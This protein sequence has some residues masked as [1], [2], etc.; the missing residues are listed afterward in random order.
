MIA[1]MTTTYVIFVVFLH[2]QNFWRIKF[3]LKKRVNYDKIHR[4]L[5]IF[6]VKSLK[7]YTDQK[8]FTRPL[9]VAPVTNMRYA[10]NQN[11]SQPTL[12]NPT[13]LKIKAQINDLQIFFSA[14]FCPQVSTMPS[15]RK[16]RL[17]LF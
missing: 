15:Q 12:I 3:T 1:T 16:T 2:E 4:K 13:K 5:P 7:I 8:K 14:T 10:P 11:A 9:P 17:A 6:C